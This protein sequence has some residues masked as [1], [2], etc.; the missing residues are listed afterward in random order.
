MAK[1]HRYFVYILECV[2]QS[3]YIGVTNNV[4]LRLHQHQ[5]GIDTQ[6]Y[7]YT[8]RPVELVWYEEFNCIDQAIA[9]EKKLKGWSRAKK[10]ALIK[11][12]YQRL[13]GLSKKKFE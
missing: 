10:I 13:P 6:S 4:E 7:T 2:D 12:E 8:K 11:G 5:T 9:F 3:F 1:T